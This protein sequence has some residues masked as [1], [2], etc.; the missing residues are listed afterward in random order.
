MQIPKKT[1]I[2]WS[3]R[4]L[5][6]KLYM[7]RGVK[8]TTGSTRHKGCE[9]GKRVR[10]GSLCHR[11]YITDTESTLPRKLEKDLWLRNGSKNNGHCAQICRWSCDTG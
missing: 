3:E 4:R 10:Q 6:D 2:D 7:D 1:G 5:I 8:T 11:F 9:D